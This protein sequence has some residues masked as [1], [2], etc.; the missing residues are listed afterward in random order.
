[1][2][3]QQFY[4][5]DT[6]CNPNANGSTTKTQRQD[7]TG[8]H[9]LHNTLGTCASGPQT[10]SVAGAPDAL[11]LSGAPDPSP[12]DPSDPPLFDYSNDFYLEPNPATDKGVQ[13]RREDAAGCNYAPTGGA[14]P[15]SQIHRWVSDPMPSAFAMTGR[16]TLEFYT[17]AINSSGRVCVYLFTRSE[18]GTPPTA[19][20]TRLLNAGG[21]NVFGGA[22]VPTN[23]WF[24]WPTSG[25]TWPTCSSQCTDL[26][27]TQERLTMTFPAITIP[28]GQR[29]GVALSVDRAVTTDDML[30]F[31]FDNPN[32]KSRLEVDTTTPLEGG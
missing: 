16:I 32:Y 8:D 11:L 17:R 15:E 14:N 9:P 3:G 2:T 24:G 13:I 28:V 12:A 22:T 7:I 5:S 21:S 25:S 26:N 27:W 4:L 18:A 10:G 31:V 19:V 30:P 6:S 20:D 29:L 23:A 1:V